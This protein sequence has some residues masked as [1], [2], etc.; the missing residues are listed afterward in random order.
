MKAIVKNVD[1]QK[2]LVVFETED[3]DY[4]WGE[5]YV[6]AGT[7]YGDLEEDDEI[8]SQFKPFNG[9]TQFRPYVNQYVV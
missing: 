5:M 4:G 7:T 6:E 8:T 2:A 9:R 3:Y 1:Y